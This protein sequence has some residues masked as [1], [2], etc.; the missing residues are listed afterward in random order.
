MTAAK[1]R[2]Q[3]T[4]K[5][6][7]ILVEATKKFY[8]PYSRRSAGS[9]AVLTARVSCFDAIELPSDHAFDITLTG[10]RSG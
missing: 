2:R 8:V 10:V 3:S 6:S 7:L 1:T 9:F 4:C 5:E